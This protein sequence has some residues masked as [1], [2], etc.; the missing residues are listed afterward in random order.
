MSGSDLSVTYL[1]YQVY[2]FAD[3]RAISGHKFQ[4]SSIIFFRD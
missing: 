4:E 3:F 2:D 1:N